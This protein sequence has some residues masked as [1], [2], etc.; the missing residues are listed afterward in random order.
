MIHTMRGY[1]NWEIS[2]MAVG[3]GMVGLWRLQLVALLALYVVAIT[4]LLPN[5]NL[6]YISS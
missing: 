3:R 1:T 5:G 6:I 2:G 4:A